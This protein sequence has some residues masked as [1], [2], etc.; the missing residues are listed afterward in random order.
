MKFND[1]SLPGLK[2]IEPDVFADNRGFFYESYSK[3]KFQEEGGID[4]VFVQDNHSKSTRGVLRG[5]HFQLPPYAQDKLVRVIQGEVFDVA[6]DIRKDSPT[7]GKWEGFTL[8][9]ENKKILFIPQGFA[10]G[11]QVISETAE[12]EYKVSNFYSKEHEQGFIWNDPIV[13]IEWPIH[14]PILS[15]KDGQYPNLQE[16]INNTH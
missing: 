4:I 7:F 9:S 5:I 6:V 10:H 14:N 15:E 13:G 8:S 11:F 3:K 2:L 12:F 1:L 16:M